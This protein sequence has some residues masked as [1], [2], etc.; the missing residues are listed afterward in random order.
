MGDFVPSPFI[1]SPPTPL[2]P[3][4]SLHSSNIS[5][6]Y[7]GLVV[8]GTAAIVLAVYNLI[9]IRWCAERQ[10]QAA[11]RRP[12]QFEG[13][14]ASISRSL[15]CQGSRNLLSSFKYRKENDDVGGRG[16][17]Q[18]RSTD[19]ECVVCL[20]AFEEGEE[21]RRLPR[22]KHSFHA[23]C[24]D[25]WLQS[26]TDCPLCRTHV[27]PP[28]LSHPQMAAYSPDNDSQEVSLNSGTTPA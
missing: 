3:S 28:P 5:M 7:Y 21:V 15:E 8:V 1:P 6:L 18:G 14:P 2:P 20:S 22:C 25:M 19:S 23:S 17:D 10:G 13:E 9:F 24:I 11:W 26:H 16:Q 12:N 4:H 27:L